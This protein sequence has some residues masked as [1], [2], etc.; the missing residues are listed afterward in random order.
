[1][2]E[3]VKTQIDFKFIL[4]VF[5]L[6]CTNV[7]KYLLII[8]FKSVNNCKSVSLFHK[9]ALLQH[10]VIATPKDWRHV[11]VGRRGNVAV[12]F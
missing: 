5:M 10:G 12:V 8:S 4:N 3:C 7:L 11:N 1:M 9:Y 2:Y 6:S